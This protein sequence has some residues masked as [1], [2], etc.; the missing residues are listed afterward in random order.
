MVGISKVFPVSSL[1][2]VS[3]LRNNFL[4]SSR[5]LSFSSFRFYHEIAT[6]QCHLQA[7]PYLYVYV[8]PVTQSSLILCSPRDV[9]CQAA[10]SMDS[11]G[12]NARAGFHF[13]LQR[14]FITQGSDSCLRNWQ[15]DS[16]PLVLPEK[17]L[18]VPKHMGV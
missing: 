14:V 11:P 10:L 9:V 12:K 2:V 5:R 7:S 3:I 18:T 6:I 17:P 16:L 4:G 1:G 8:C 13:L 15:A